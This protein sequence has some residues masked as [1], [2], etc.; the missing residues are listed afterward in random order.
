MADHDM[1]EQGDE[2]AEGAGEDRFDRLEDKVDRLAAAV[3]GL[4]GRGHQAAEKHEAEKLDR[5]TRAVDQAEDVRAAMREA[6]EDHER[7]KAADSRFTDLESQ[8]KKVAAVV[9]KAP[10]QFRRVEVAMGWVGKDDA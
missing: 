5:P 1:P 10:R 8:V 9:E 7:Q 2:G 6:I 4:V 3:A